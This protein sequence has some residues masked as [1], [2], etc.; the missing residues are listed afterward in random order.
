PE[1]IKPIYPGGNEYFID[2]NGHAFYCI[3]EYYRTGEILWNDELKSKEFPVSKRTIDLEIEY[4]KIPISDNRII[5]N[6]QEGASV[7]DK[8]CNYLI[9]FINEAMNRFISDISVTYYIDGSGSNCFP[10]D[11]YE[12][13]RW[14]HEFSKQG[15]AFCSNEKIVAA[16][17]KRLANHFAS[18]K[19]TFNQGHKHLVQYASLVVTEYLDIT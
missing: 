13:G 12:K 7:F 5:R 9:L 10:F 2:R 15:Y 4:F 8:F 17:G 1:S 6:L 3:L 19:V 11:N 16:I 18:I 14:H